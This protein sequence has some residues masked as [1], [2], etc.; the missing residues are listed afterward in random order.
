MHKAIISES[1]TD[2]YSL[3]K[4][5]YKIHT[6]IGSNDSRVYIDHTAFGLNNIYLTVLHAVPL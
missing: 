4:A 2:I 3:L 6:T 5:K 1:K